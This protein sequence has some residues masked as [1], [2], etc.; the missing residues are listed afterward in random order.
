MERVEQAPSFEEIGTAVA[1]YLENLEKRQLDPHRPKIFH[2]PSP[3]LLVWP[4]QTP[5]L[6]RHLHSGTSSL[7]AETLSVPV[8]T[9]NVPAETLSVPVET[10]S[11]PAETLCA[12]AETWSVPAETLS[13]PLE[14]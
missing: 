2:T 3:M 14:T 9:L 5:C 4:V 11:V 8:E 6:C 7:P 1:R 12:T 10:L 13:V